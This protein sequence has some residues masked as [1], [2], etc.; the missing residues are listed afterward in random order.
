[1]GH[2]L[3]D[4]GEEGDDKEQQKKDIHNLLQTL[5]YLTQ[6]SA[7]Y[8]TLHIII[9]QCIYYT[10]HIIIIHLDSLAFLLHVCLNCM[11]EENPPKIFPPVYA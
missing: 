7:M 2:S 9:L 11:E 5:E 8:H 6:N 10:L 3:T 1:M 4:E